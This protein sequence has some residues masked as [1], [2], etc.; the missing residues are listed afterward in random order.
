MDNKNGRKVFQTSYF[1]HIIRNEQELYEIRK[2]IEQNPM[3]W[4]L[5]EY[6]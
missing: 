4:E 1:D 2:Y 6:Y 5:D 3:K